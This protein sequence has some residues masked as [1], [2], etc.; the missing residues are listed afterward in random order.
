MT[1]VQYHDTIVLM[2]MDIYLFHSTIPLANAMGLKLCVNR[3]IIVET[4]IPLANAMGLKL[5]SL[6]GIHPFFNYTPG[7]CH[8]SETGR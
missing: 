1:F 2:V 8:G 5:T 7:K 6:S 3:I 4:T